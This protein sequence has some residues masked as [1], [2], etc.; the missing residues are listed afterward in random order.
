MNRNKKKS[1][2]K[3]ESKV[4]RDDRNEKTETQTAPGSYKDCSVW[5]V[6]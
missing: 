5:I 6:R 3:H 4:K 2:E 1:G